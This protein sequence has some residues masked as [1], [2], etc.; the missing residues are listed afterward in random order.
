MYRALLPVKGLHEVKSRLAP[1]LTPAE[2]GQL[3]LSMLHHVLQTLQQSEQFERITVVSPDFH[4]LT[5]VQHWGAYAAVEEQP[6]HN[7]ALDAAAR[8]ELATGATALLT[9]SADLPLLEPDDVLNLIQ[10]SYHYEV[11]LAPSRDGTGTNALLVRPPLVLP[12][13]FGVGSLQRYQREA[14]QRYLR[15]TTYSSNGLA[16]DV[17]TIDDLEEFRH[18]E[19][20]NGIS[21]VSYHA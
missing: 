16:F 5:Q 1:Y 6:G 13:V 17:D 15:C 21:L 3:V 20:Q 10:A 8:H 4:V 12:Y 14:R 19:A 2:R 7:P 11:V 18:Y 9:I